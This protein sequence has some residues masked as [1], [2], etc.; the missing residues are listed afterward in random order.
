MISVLLWIGT[1]LFIFIGFWEALA[2]LTGQKQIP[3]WSRLIRTIWRRDRSLKPAIF[4]ITVTVGFIL[5]LW[6]AF[7]FVTG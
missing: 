6:L 1:I 5:T 4:V 2:L 7:H 3:T